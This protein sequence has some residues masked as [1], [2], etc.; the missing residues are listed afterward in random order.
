MTEMQYSGVETHF[1]G[2]QMNDRDQQKTNLTES[3]KPPA[4]KTA[5]KQIHYSPPTSDGQGGR[6]PILNPLV[7]PS[8]QA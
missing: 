8:P 2:T 6:Y 4:G 1:F 5:H 3:E 7:Q